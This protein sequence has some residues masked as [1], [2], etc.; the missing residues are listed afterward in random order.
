MSDRSSPFA[1]AIAARKS[2]QVTALPS[3]RSKYRSSPCD[4]KQDGSSDNSVEWQQ[5][6]SA[7]FNQSDRPRFCQRHLS[8][9]FG[10]SSVTE[11]R[12]IMHSAPPAF[13][14]Q[15]AS[16]INQVPPMRPSARAACLPATLRKPALPSSVW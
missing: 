2:S 8:I 10:C 16:N 15:T 9:I 5:L 4:E 1:S 11:L 13:S 3:C 7:V 12:S 14:T 6:H